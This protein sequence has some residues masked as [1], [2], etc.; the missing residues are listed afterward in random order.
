MDVNDGCDGWMW[1]M[2]CDGW[3]WMMDDDGDGMV[4]MLPVYLVLKPR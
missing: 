4:E 2:K 3:M 1:M